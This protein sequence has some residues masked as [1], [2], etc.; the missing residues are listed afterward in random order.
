MCLAA[1][2]AGL[3]LHGVEVQSVYADLCR[4]N[5]AAN[6]VDALIWEADLRDLPKDL[7]AKTFDHVFANPPYFDRAKGSQ[8]TSD[9]RD[10]AF[11][12]QTDI[13]DWIDTASR[14]LKPKGTL[15]LIQK[16]DRLPDVLKAIDS[17]LGSVQVRPVS[18]RTGRPADRVLI[19]AI[20]GGR[21]DFRLLAPIDLHEGPTHGG[22]AEDYRPEIAAVLR[23][24]AAFP[25]F[26]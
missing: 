5:A 3:A 1:R 10:I 8:S 15:T 14:R 16:A 23:N 18:G 17:R 12:G 7:R 20:K 2:T 26:D 25:A 19:R 21:A 22:D 9:H 4:R 6:A 24:G 11:G 13:S